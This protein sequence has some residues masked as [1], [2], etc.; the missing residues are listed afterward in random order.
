MLTDLIP[1][2]YKILIVAI[3]ALIIFGAGSVAGWKVCHADLQPKLDN[4]T[5]ERAQWQASFK[6][7]SASTDIQNAEVK[8]LADKATKREAQAAEAIKAA[9]AGA[10]GKNAQAQRIVQS[11][12]PTG[13]ELCRAASEAFDAELAEE[14]GAK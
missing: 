8:E 3:V 1:T 10:Q 14:R 4:A 5:T 13:A 12:P 2:P 11:Q 9:K 6:D 7:L